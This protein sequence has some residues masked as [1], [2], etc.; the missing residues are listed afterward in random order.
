VTEAE[1][2]PSA[3][4]SI[5]APVELRRLFPGVTDDAAAREYERAIAGWRPLLVRGSGA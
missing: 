1:P 3:L 2:P 5:R 4:R